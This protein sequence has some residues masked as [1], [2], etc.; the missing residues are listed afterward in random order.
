MNGCDVTDN[1]F[2]SVYAYLNKLRSNLLYYKILNIIFL[3]NTFIAY[4]LSSFSTKKTDPKL[5]LPIKP[6]TSNY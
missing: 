2:L 6:I 5:P 4:N 1:I 3:S